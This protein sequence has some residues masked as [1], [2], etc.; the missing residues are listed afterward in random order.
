MNYNIDPEDYKMDD[1]FNSSLI[2]GECDSYNLYTILNKIQNKYNINSFLDV[3]SGC[4]KIIIYLAKNFNHIYFE[5]VEIQKNR[6]DK[7]IKLLN[8]DKYHFENISFLN[9]DFKNLYFGN[10]DVIYCCNTI[11]TEEDND[12]LY[13]KIL[14]EFKG[15]F[16]L[17]TMSCKIIQYYKEKIMI[18]SSWHPCIFIYIYNN[19]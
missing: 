19:L 13:N 6:Y 9:D 18:R 17:T 2:Y 11:F 16:I 12:I 3:G 8:N 14:N 15:T 4:G 10:Y 7:S 1:K 5:G